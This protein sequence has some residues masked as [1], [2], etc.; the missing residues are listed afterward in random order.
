MFDPANGIDRRRRCKSTG[1]ARWL[2]LI[3]NAKRWK[4]EEPLV[5]ELQLAGRTIQLLAIK[6]DKRDD[7]YRH[8]VGTAGYVR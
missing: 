6:G 5:W 1:T 8:S 4:P 2:S 7:A 3:G